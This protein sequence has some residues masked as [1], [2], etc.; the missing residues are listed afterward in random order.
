MNMKNMYFIHDLSTEKLFPNNM[1]FKIWLFVSIN[2]LAWYETTTNFTI[3][4]CTVANRFR[5]YNR[6]LKLDLPSFK[7]PAAQQKQTFV[8]FFQRSKK[9]W[10]NAMQ[11]T[12]RRRCKP[13]PFDQA[14]RKHQ[15]YSKAHM[16]N[17]KTDIYQYIH[18][19][20]Y[21]HI[22]IYNVRDFKNFWHPL[23]HFWNKNFMRLDSLSARVELN[24]HPFQIHLKACLIYLK[25]MKS[26]TFHDLHT[27]FVSEQC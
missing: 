22:N 5:L 26:L 3:L 7:I 16:Y 13:S 2:P 20:Q 8:I 14:K 1:C 12:S 21:I 6:F 4:C 23:Q 27:S 11:N 10:F 25:S 17:I 15:L 9:L 18:L 24:L 19:F